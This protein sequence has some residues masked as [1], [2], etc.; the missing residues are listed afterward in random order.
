MG[1]F[2]K[3]IH[4]TPQDNF[5]KRMLLI[6][7]GFLAVGFGFAGVFL[8]VL[9]TTPFLLLAA[10]CFARS[11]DRF[12]S[13]LISNRICGEYIR[14]YRAG[15]G[16]TLPHKIFV[17]AL[18]WS[19]ISYSAFL[20]VKLPWVRILLIIIAAG[21]TIHILMIRTYRPGKSRTCGIDGPDNAAAVPGHDCFDSVEKP[22]KP[23]DTGAS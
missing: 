17:L 7:S 3:G 4:Q 23:M 10:Y 9:P 19:L 21:V 5:M 16:M 22:L 6:I 20:A 15:R 14:N 8:P 18:L 13:W 2:D 1:F 11:S 12:Y